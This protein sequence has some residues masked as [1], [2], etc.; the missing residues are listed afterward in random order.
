MKIK[1]IL[2]SLDLLPK[3]RR[4]QNFLR[5]QGSAHRIVEFAE[6]EKGDAVLE[7]G[8]GL[9]AITLPMLDR[10]VKL[11]AVEIEPKLAQFLQ[12]YAFALNPER[13]ICADIRQITPQ[14]VCQLLAQESFRL[15]SN[16]PYSISSELLLWILEH[17][18]FIKD[19]CLLLQQEFARRIAAE[20]GSREGGSLSVMRALYATAEL[21]PVIKGSCFHPR[22]EVDSQLLRLKILKQPAVKVDDEIFFN[23]VVR[24]SFSQRRKTLLN[25]LAGGKLGLDKQKIELAL[26]QSGIKAQ[27]R[28]ESLCLEEFSQLS[29]A[30]WQHCVLLKSEFHREISS[31]R[32]AENTTVLKL[33]SR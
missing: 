20:P 30:L 15:V 13:V 27:R 9:G 26:A 5:E 32:T 11:A 22:A 2:Q 33:D 18:H 29:A 10:G 31:L 19:C 21:G 24:A 12:E 16:V 25:S 8:P 4:G 14:Q 7:V 17:R 28:A 3:K 1:T 6:L 23:R